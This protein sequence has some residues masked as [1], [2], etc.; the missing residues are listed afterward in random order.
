MLV[1]PQ[2]GVSSGACPQNTV[3]VS[4]SKDWWAEILLDMLRVWP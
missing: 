3:A 1:R 2:E 4:D